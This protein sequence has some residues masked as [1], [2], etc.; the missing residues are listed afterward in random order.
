MEN[1]KSVGWRNANGWGLLELLILAVGVS[2]ASV[3]TEE[4]NLCLVVD[5]R[6]LK[7][8]LCWCIH[9]VRELH[10]DSL[11]TWVVCFFYH[12][13]RKGRGVVANLV[14]SIIA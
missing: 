9:Q 10:L 8:T 4:V 5:A 12:L 14:T 1:F 7:M 2:I 3:K 6:Q 11:L 13:S